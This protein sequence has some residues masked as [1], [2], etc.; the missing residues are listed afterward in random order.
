MVRDLVVFLECVYSELS[1]VCMVCAF[2]PG[3]NDTKTFSGVREGS[4]AN[5]SCF[6]RTLP[7]HCVGEFPNGYDM[8]WLPEG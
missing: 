4:A 5:R 8:A 2:C 6:G 7:L 3:L 1:G